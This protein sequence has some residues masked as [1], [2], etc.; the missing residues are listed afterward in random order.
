MTEYCLL[1]TRELT[2]KSESAHH[3]IPKTF[4]GKEIVVLHKICHRKLH[5]T[6]TEREMKKYY[7]TIDRLLENEE[8]EK[9]VKW[10]QKKDPDY[11]DSSKETTVRKNKRKR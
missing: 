11:Y 7:H 9:F 2:E 8:I 4:K 10:V 6:I 5:A 3:L 1:C